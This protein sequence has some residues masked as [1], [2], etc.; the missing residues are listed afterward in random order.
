MTSNGNENRP[1]LDPQLQ[2]LADYAAIQPKGTSSSQ[3][4]YDTILGAIL[5]RKVRS[6]QRLAEIPV[7]KAIKLGRTPVREALMRL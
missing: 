3:Q 7:A 4:A 2:G 1:A 5:N 6:G